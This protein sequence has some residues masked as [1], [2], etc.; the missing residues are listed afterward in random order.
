MGLEELEEINIPERQL[1]IRA[2]EGQDHSEGSAWR[3]SVGLNA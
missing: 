1:S 2:R 3:A